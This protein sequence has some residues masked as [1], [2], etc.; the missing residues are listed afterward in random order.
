MLSLENVKYKYDE[1]FVIEN[2]SF[3]LEKGETLAIVGPSGS[4]KTTLL[5]LILGGIQPD[6]GKIVL[7]S[8]N[9]TNLEI[10][11]RNIGYCPQ[12]QLLFPHLNVFDNIAMGLKAKKVPKQS[13]KEQVE[14][15]AKMSEIFQLL[16]R[17]TN[18]ISG[19][20]KQRVSILRA[21]ANHPRLLLLDEPFHNLD[22]QIK[23]QIV[24]Y[25]KRMQSLMNITMIFVT[26]DISEA[27]LLADKILILIDGKMRQVGSSKQM[28]YNPK[29]YEVA[30]TMGL[31]NVYRIKTYNK[32]A[33]SIILEFGEIKLFGLSYEGHKNVLINPTCINL[34]SFD[35]T[36]V[37]VFHGLVKGIIFDLLA[38][39]R[40]LTIQI[41]NSNEEESEKEQIIQITL[42]LEGL[43]IK[44]NQEIDF[45][46]TSDCLKFF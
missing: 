13:I 43:E 29:S 35:T 16:K 38:Q 3:D 20:Q 7:D 42:N 30:K 4:G 15:L 45:E 8:A 41:L 10:E 44:K 25:I 22:A 23:E 33:S 12:D 18:Q 19:G 5:K 6:N 46:I 27:K 21:L 34:S 17:K 40:I 14:N 9:I 37:N 1:N 2:V 36:K 26:H 28:S 24:N 32:E 31:P 39:K 11:H